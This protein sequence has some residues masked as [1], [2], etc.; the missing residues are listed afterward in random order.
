MSYCK[1][2]EDSGKGTENFHL[3]SLESPD[4]PNISREN[5]IHLN[6]PCDAV[7]VIKV[8]LTHYLLPQFRSQGQHDRQDESQPH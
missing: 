2:W 3:N 6:L 1:D 7:A 8:T 5:E 4:P